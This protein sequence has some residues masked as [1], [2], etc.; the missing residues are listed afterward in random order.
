MKAGKFLQAADAFQAAIKH[1]PVRHYYLNLA[2]AYREMGLS[3]AAET[4]VHEI[5]V[6]LT[7]INF[8]PSLR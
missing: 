7:G 5:N 6:K 1:E 4:I 8:F 2:A 3:A